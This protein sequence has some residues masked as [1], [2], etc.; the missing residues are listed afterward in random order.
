V[1]TGIAVRRECC[2]SPSVFNVYS[3]DFINEALEGFRNFKKGGKVIRTVKHSNHLV[4]LA[5]EETKLRSICDGQIGIVRCY[6]MEINVKKK[7]R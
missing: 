7:L 3:K 6:G 1:K 5:V 4:L 2:L